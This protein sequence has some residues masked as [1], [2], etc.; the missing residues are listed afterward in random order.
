VLISLLLWML[1]AQA[2]PQPAT[3]LH[4]VLLVDISGSMTLGTFRYDP[5]LLV[6][7]ARG[8]ADA[9]HEDDG[10]RIGSVGEHVVI[11]AR[12][13]QGKKAVLAA[14]LAHREPMGGPSPL[15][16]ALD[17][18]ATALHS[19]QGGKVIILVT[20]GMSTA[21]RLSFAEALD[22]LAQERIAVYVLRLHR[23]EAVEPDPSVRL[24]QLA[25]QT[26]GAYGS[27]SR[28]GISSGLKRLVRDARL[29]ASKAA[30]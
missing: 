10:V 20:D 30:R 2:Q 18:G 11:E 9:L 16:D 25:E 23:S 29:S 15:W 17:G 28:K 26:Q 4:I 7:A 12:E 21:N 19:A 5:D 27:A 24:R 22:R 1:A 14:A 13:V 3:A 6:D 8:L